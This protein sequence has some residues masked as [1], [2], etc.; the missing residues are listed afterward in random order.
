KEVSIELTRNN[1][2][3]SLQVT[4][5]STGKI[6]IGNK[7][8]DSYFDITQRSY[9]FFEAIPAGINE[10]LRVITGYIDQFKL[11]FTKEGA[12][13]IGGFVAIGGMFPKAWDWSSFWSLTA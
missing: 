3:I 4:I 11:V 2:R 12:S 10:A 6:G 5:P 13:Q 9:S 8:P 1:E 7:S